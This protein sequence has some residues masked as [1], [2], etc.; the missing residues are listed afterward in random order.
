MVV[1][2]KGQAKE[3]SES[4]VGPSGEAFSRSDQAGFPEALATAATRVFKR[5]LQLLVVGG[6][7]PCTFLCPC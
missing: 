5:H 7:I 6:L 2:V 1:S 3:A 4:G